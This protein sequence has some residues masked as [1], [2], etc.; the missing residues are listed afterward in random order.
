MVYGLRF[1]SLKFRR[2]DLLDDVALD[3][4]AVLDVVKVFEPDAALVALAHLGDVVLEAAQ[5]ADAALPGDD[6]VADE[7]GARVAADDPVDDAAARD[8]AGLRHPEGLE[9]E[10]LAQDLLGLDLVEHADHGRADLLLDLVDDRVEPDVHVLLPRELGGPHLRP[11]VE[12]DDDDR[13]PRRLGLRRRGEQHVRLGDGAD[14]GADDAHLDRVGRELGE[15]RL[16]HLDRALHVGLDDGQQFLDLRLAERLDAALGGL[17]E[18]LLA[19]DHL[20]VVRDLLRLGDVGDDLEGLA[21][22]RHALEA[23]HLDGRGRAGL[24][25]VVA[26]VVV[27]R[28][29]LAEDLPDDER[30]ADAQRALLDEHRGDG[31]AAA[32]ELGLEDNAGG[33]PRRARLQVQDVGRE[34]DGLQQRPDV[35]L[36]LGRDGDHLDV[37]APL[38]GL[39]PLHREFLADAVGVGVGLV[40]LVDGDD[41]GHVRGARVLDG[42]DGLRHDAVVGRDDEHDHVGRL[43]AARAHHGERLVAG[44]VE[45]DDAALVVGVVGARHLDAVGADVLGDAA[46]LAPCD[47]RGA[48]AVEQRGLAVVDVTHDGDDGRA[49]LLRVVGVGLDQLLQLLVEAEAA[50]QLLRHLVVERLVERGEDAALEQE[51]LNVLRAD[52]GLFGKLLDG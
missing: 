2:G 38:D 45:E 34:Q 52:A 17:R 26:A 46:G 49:R 32:V 33:Q 36:L 44:R 39:E 19:R 47:V 16:Q 7:A 14:A 29:H 50:A 3:L 48:D 41:D 13:A 4:V 20:A 21:R 27:H 23:E 10:R 51:R 24:V 5:G 22:L 40:D 6:A 28:A 18:R 25:D 8:D 11:H 35:L 43:R 1:T 42:L 37:A 30:L 31:A 9:D 15:R 12:A